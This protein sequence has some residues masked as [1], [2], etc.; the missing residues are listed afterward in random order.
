MDGQDLKSCID[1]STR[2][3][4]DFRK[5]VRTGENVARLSIICETLCDPESEVMPQKVDLLTIVGWGM[6]LMPLL[7]MW[8]EIGGHAALCVVQGGHV[9]TIGAFYVDCAGLTDFPNVVVAC[10][11]VFVNAVLAVVAYRLWRGA[12]TDNL[13]LVLWLVW[14]SEAFVA[15]GYFCFSGVTG[16]GDLGTGTGGSLQMLPMP[17]AIRGAE[18]L[19]GV[20][21]YISLVRAAIGSLD[22]MLGTGPDTRTA[23][24]RIAHGYYATAGI[25]AVLVGLMIP[26]GIVITIMSAAASSFGGLAGFISIGFAG[27]REGTAAAFVINRNWPVVCLGAVVLLAFSVVLGPSRHF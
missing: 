15:A 26:V 27:R 7:T 5:S 19:I 13:R 22:T 3:L 24:R 16:F 17:I 4:L 11:G 23:R 2:L 6:L 12:R 21:A 8:H 18:L 9:T 20:V 10:A 1:A 25:G 14:V